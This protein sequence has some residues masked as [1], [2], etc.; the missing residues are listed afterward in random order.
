MNTLIWSKLKS[1]AH[2]TMCMEQKKKTTFAWG[3]AYLGVP[4]SNFVTME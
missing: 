2:D 1:G 4:A 3:I